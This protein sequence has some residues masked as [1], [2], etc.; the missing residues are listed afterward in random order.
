MKK[1]SELYSSY[2][3]NF[4]EASLKRS[5]FNAFESEEVVSIFVNIPEKMLRRKTEQYPNGRTNLRMLRFLTK[6]VTILEKQ[7]LLP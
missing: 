4:N 5:L 1:E 7:R 6:R 3:N 2:I